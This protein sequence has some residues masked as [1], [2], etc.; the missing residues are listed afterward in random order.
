M[1]DLDVEAMLD[2]AM[3]E[4]GI[5]KEVYITLLSSPLL[6]FGRRLNVLCVLIIQ[7]IPFIICL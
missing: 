3:L 2:E 5:T 7:L 4:E 6:P 1:D